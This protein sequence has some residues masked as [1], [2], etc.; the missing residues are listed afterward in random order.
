MNDKPKSELLPLKI[1]G[2]IQ[3]FQRTAAL[4]AAIDIDLF[5]AISDQGSTAKEIAARCSVS[6][7]GTR[8][9]CDF[10]CVIDLLRKRSG[11]Y[12][13]TEDA[14]LYLDRRSPKFIADVAI[15][16][17][18][19][20]ALLE[21]FENLAQAVRNGGTALPGAGTVASEHPYW[22]QFA[23]ALAPI[24]AANAALL[25]NLLELS[26]SAPMR[27]LDVACGHGHYGIAIAKQNPRVEVFAQDW[28][29]VLEVA[30]GNARNAGVSERY[31]AIPGDVFGATLG[32]GYNLAL[33]TNFLPDFGPA[34]CEQL[35][36]RIRRSLT[37]D[38]RAV[39]LQWIPDDD[40][41]SP[42]NAPMLALSL[43]AQTPNGDVYTFWELEEIFRRAGFAR[44]EMRELGPALQRVVIAHQR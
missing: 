18:A 13:L 42:P 44:T 11:R 30:I 23:R 16:T 14:A 31:H 15:Q 9:L 38:G 8:V 28:P 21:G 27:I 34:E 24:G 5:T 25:T 35:L 29:A 33:I 4:K 39:A 37:G 12:Q 40:R 17:Y 3:S 10:L 22:T 36:A 43:L 26:S 6:P 32:E 7:R 2:I 41:L 19:G 1:F 20:G